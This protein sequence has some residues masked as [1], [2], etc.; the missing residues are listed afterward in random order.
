MKTKKEIACGDAVHSNAARAAGPP[1]VSRTNGVTCRFAPIEAAV[2]GKALHRHS[3]GS[4]SA[5]SWLV[6]VVLMSREGVQQREPLRRIVAHFR[7]K[8]ARS[9][10]SHPGG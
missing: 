3:L 2:T 5:S 1:V 4:L 6:K 9:G 7:E 10:R 8:L